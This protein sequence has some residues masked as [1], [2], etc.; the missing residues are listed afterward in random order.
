[1]LKFKPELIVFDLDG[2]LL[3]TIADLADAVCFALDEYGFPPRSRAEV[4]GFVGN[5]VLKLIERALPDGSKDPE[6]VEKVYKSFNL[7]YSE[8]CADKTRPYDGIAE[9]LKYLKNQGIK[10]AVLSNKPDEFTNYL[11]DKFFH[12]IFDKVVGSSGSTP[13]KPDPSGELRVISE[14]GTV[15]EKTLHIG[16]SDTDI[17]TAKNAGVDIIACSWGYRTRETLKMAGAEKIADTVEEL[18]KYF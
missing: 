16:D 6:T 5:G 11:I 4:T 2:T 3:D 9:L 8:H 10:L 7:R 18:R 1:M 17:Q 14:L 15:P 12:G 13:R